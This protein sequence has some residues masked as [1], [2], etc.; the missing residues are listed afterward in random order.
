MGRH[1]KGGLLG[2]DAEGSS[3]DERSTRQ[4]SQ[5]TSVNPAPYQSVSA[6]KPKPAPHRPRGALLARGDDQAETAP[7]FRISQPLAQRV[8]G[9]V[10]YGV[11]TVVKGSAVAQAFRAVVDRVSHEVADETPRME[12][13]GR[14]GDDA[15][16]AEVVDSSRA[17]EYLPQRP[18]GA[19]LA[20]TSAH[21]RD[22][23]CLMTGGVFRALFQ[24]KPKS[25]K[26]VKK[27]A[28]AVPTAEYD[29]VASDDEGE[30]A[31]VQPQRPIMQQPVRREGW[32]NINIFGRASQPR[33]GAAA[34]LLRSV[35]ES[36][37]VGDVASVATL[38]MPMR[39]TQQPLQQAV[40]PTV[41][42]V[43]KNPSSV[44]P[45]QDIAAALGDDFAQLVIDRQRKQAERQALEAKIEE[46]ERA[47][48]EAEQ[49]EQEEEERRQAE[50]ERAEEES[51]A[52]A[53]EDERSRKLN[54]KYRQEEK[55]RQE[56]ERKRAEEERRLK[57]MQRILEEA[58][59]E[60][61]QREKA[62]QQEAQRQLILAAAK[63]NQ[64]SLENLFE[65]HIQQKESGFSKFRNVVKRLFSWINFLNVGPLANYKHEQRAQRLETARSMLQI[66]KGL[67][68]SNAD[69]Q[70]K[71][72]FA[73]SGVGQQYLQSYTPASGLFANK[74]LR[75]HWQSTSADKL[76]TRETLDRAVTM[77]FK[78]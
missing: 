8:R 55:V 56:A 53:A 9:A 38:V 27:S 36:D 69:T 28:P 14:V 66:V 71:L 19:L 41:S 39:T 2:S 23:D 42:A 10:S 62:R 74:D 75:K 11:E 24:R 51:T 6:R 70:Q 7:A 64:Q 30:S 29:A 47:C 68:L 54:E 22:T 50:R 16:D 18:R 21:K 31:D 57:E 73:V 4:S 25:D 67:D 5:R 1:K 15:D 78:P 37:F 44:V 72:A 46:L 76:N 61:A 40:K 59:R 65:A 63:Q 13:Y 45:E 20:D 17:Q 35:D 33:E 48:A 52:F 26:P 12:G 32:S 58:A 49:R 34:S 60:E 77:L 43:T 3:G